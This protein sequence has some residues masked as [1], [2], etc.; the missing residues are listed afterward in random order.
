MRAQSSVASNVV[1]NVNPWKRPFLNDNTGGPF[2]KKKRAEGPLFYRVRYRLNE[3]LAATCIQI[4]VRF[5]GPRSGV[6]NRP[7]R[8]GPRP[9]ARHPVDRIV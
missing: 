7:G 8:S 6:N 3:N 4:V 1:G 5:T 9:A 2:V